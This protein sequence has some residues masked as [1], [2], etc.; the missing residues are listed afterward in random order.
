MYCFVNGDPVDV[1]PSN[2]AARARPI[3][4]S[5]ISLHFSL[6]PIVL[7]IWLNTFEPD[8]ALDV[9]DGVPVPR[10]VVFCI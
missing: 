4:D 10:C 1:Y 6:S 5:L 9:I 2:H 8:N 7:W 3:A